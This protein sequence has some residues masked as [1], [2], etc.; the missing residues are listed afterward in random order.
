MIGLGSGSVAD[1]LLMISPSAATPAN[2]VKRR[3]L[4]DLLS[5]DNGITYNEG[6][7]GK[8]R[9]G[10]PN[11]NDNPLTMDRFINLDGND[12]AI[13]T[14]TS[15]G[16]V[17]AKFEGGTSGT[18]YGVSL[19]ADGVEAINLTGRTNINT[20]GSATTYIGNATSPTVVLG[21]TDINVSGPARTSIGST[22]LASEVKI[23]AT[24]NTIGFNGA[25]I[26][27]TEIYG[28]L[29]KRNGN[30]DFYLDGTDEFHVETPSG[31]T[32]L[33]MGEALPTPG[34][35]VARAITPTTSGELLVTD[36]GVKLNVSGAGLSASVLA[37]SAGT[38]ELNASGDFSL[39]SANLSV[40]S[41]G[42]ITDNTGAVEINDDLT[43][44]GVTNINVTGT[45]ATTIGNTDATLTLLGQSVGVTGDVTINDNLT[46]N[47][48]TSLGTSVTDDFSLTSSGLNVSLTGE[49][50]NNAGALVVNDDLTVTGVTNINVT[51]TAATTIGNTDATLTLLGQSVG[52]TGDV[53]IN[54]DLTVNGSTSL[55][56]NATDDFTLTSSGLNVALNGDLTNANGAVVVN[57]DLT[58]TGLTNINVTGT[59]ATTIG[60]TDATLTLLGQS[61]GVT[62]D[63]TIND[64]LTVNGNTAL[65]TTNAD[66]FTLTSSGLNVATSGI[67]TDDNS[68]VEIQD[69][70]SVNSG[71]IDLDV[72]SNNLSIIGLSAGSVT[73]E[74]LLIDPATDVVKRKPL[75]DLLAADAGI[76]YNESGSGKM[77]LGSANGTGNPLLGDRWINLDNNDLTFTTNG[78]GSTV[79]G[80]EGGSAG[81]NYGVAMNANG[82]GSITL[83]GATNIN[84]SGSSA[85]SIGTTDG[86]FTLAS[87]NLNITSAGVI[88]DLVGA[89]ELNDDV[90]I[91]GNLDVT[92]TGTNTI[93]D[94]LATNTILGTTS[95][96]GTTDI[97]TTGTA[98]TSIGNATGTVSVTGTT[99]MKDGSALRFEDADASNYSSFEVGNQS[100]DL[101]YVLPTSAPTATNN[102]LKA[103]TTTNPIT[104]AWSN[105]NSAVAYETN[106][107]G[108][109]TGAQ[110]NVTVPN[111]AT[112]MRVSASA[113]LELNGLSPTGVP[114]GRI[115]VLVNVGAN[116]ITLK[117][118]NS[119][120]AGAGFILPA[121][122]DIILAADGSVTVMYDAA[123][124]GWRVLAVN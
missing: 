85:T 11:T 63:V 56:T 117:D 75:S 17:V 123:S 25:T 100:V 60:N 14:G 122:A 10:A 59:A 55:G 38:I 28:D 71:N 4:A 29:S 39:T 90:T 22:D 113:A 26:S 97:N 27:S 99:T 33:S 101:Q 83:Y 92:G 96:T 16:S 24:L 95:L 3:P 74:L 32:A 35:N 7:L 84:V 62:G 118:N 108:A 66:D 19:N 49:L 105:P 18:D 64:N 31:K 98:S 79:L 110:D 91:S 104:L 8:F 114:N 41:S 87:T 77:R 72:T 52:V 21:Q 67:I 30:A 47:G 70:L 5:A 111:D 68:A 116:A 20:T 81:S 80:L 42:V 106:S 103:T 93:G 2:V 89:V 94:A 53:T 76:T 6:S 107:P 57:D 43:V 88:N 34:F 102:I 58:V 69:D 9:L 23:V 112:V 54:D 44:T 115:V 61:V 36:E 121:D 109:W 46:V 65:G 1:D 78:G 82:T 124:T 15:G 50:S 48:N 13:T 73:D 12:L 45:A 37:S 86:A 120:T 119:G 51:G 40:S